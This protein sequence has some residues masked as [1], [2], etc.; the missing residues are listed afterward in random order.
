MFIL[1]IGSMTIQAQTNKAEKV[2]NAINKRMWIEKDK[3]FT[4]AVS[5]RGVSM[6]TIDLK[7]F[8]PQASCQQ[9]SNST[10]SSIP[11]STCSPSNPPPTTKISTSS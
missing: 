10:I 2:K 3:C 11:C 9:C 5:D 4:A 1:L 7:E 8:Y 6:Y